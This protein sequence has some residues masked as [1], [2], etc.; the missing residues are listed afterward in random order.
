MRFLLLFVSLLPGLS[1]A[2][3]QD[4]TVLEKLITPYVQQ[5][6]GTSGMQVNI[7]PSPIDARLLLPSCPAPE[8]F[9]PPGAKLWGRTTVGIRCNNPAWSIYVP[10]LVQFFGPVVITTRALPHGTVIQPQDLRIE[11]GELTA[12]GTGTLARTD[13]AIGK[14]LLGA[15]PAGFPLRTNQLRAPQLVTSGQTIRLVGSAGGI[16]VSNQGKAMA[17]GVLGE[18]IPIKMNNGRVIYGTITASGMAA[19]EF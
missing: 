2:Q 18:R 9:T 8:A 6:T 10:T 12:L 15:L 13:D 17:N 4:L 16:E 5:Q 1:L 19:I 11:A 14:T 3:P 7:T